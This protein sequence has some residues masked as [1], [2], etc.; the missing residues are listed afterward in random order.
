MKLQDVHQHFSGSELLGGS[1]GIEREGLRVTENGRL[2]QTDHPEI[3][4]SKLDNPYITTD[5]SESQIEVVTPPYD[6]LPRTYAVLEGLCDIVNNEIGPDEYL[7]PG[8]MPCV[9]PDD[10]DI[11]IAKYGDS[12]KAKEYEKYRR[13]LIGKYGSKKQLLTGIHF[14][15][16]LSDAFIE[17]LRRIE[18][19]DMSVRDFRDRVYLKIA[20]GYLE[21]RWLVIYLTGCSSARHAS[22]DCA[23][24]SAMVQADSESYVSDEGP[25]F[26]NSACGYK[27]LVDFFPSYD[28]VEAYVKD[29]QSF[30]DSGLI[31]EAKELYTQI[32]LKTKDRD[33][34]LESLKQTG[35]EYLEIRTIDLNLFDK[36][37]VA[38]ND[39]R[40]VQL[41]LL[42]SLFRDETDY[43]DWQ[44]E[45]LANELRTASKGLS[46]ALKLLS[47][48]SEIPFKEYA[49]EVIGAI[50][51]MDA[52]LELGCSEIISE[53]RGR[54]EKPETTYA[55]CE[56]ALV[57][58]DGYLP[59]MMKFAKAYKEDSYHFRYLF[60]GFENYELSTQ[61]L[62]KEAITRGLKVEELDPQD[63][64]ISVTGKDGTG[65]LIKQA[66]KTQADNYASVLAMENKVVTKKI[67]AQHGIPVPEG[68][69]FTSMDAARARLSLY[70][71]RP[72]VIKPKSTNYGTGIFIFEHG[73]SEK[74]LLDAAEGAFKYDDTILIEEYLPGPEYRFLTIGGKT[75]AVMRRVAANV[76]GDGKSTIRELMDKKND[77]PFRGNH[78]ETPLEN[79][80]VDQQT[81][82]Y[83]KG[84]GLTPESVPEDS[85]TVYLR[86]NSNISTG[87]D[88]VDVTDE[89]PAYFKKIAEEAADAIGAVFCGVDM[90]IEDYTNTQSVYG[91]IELNFN[92]A[93]HMHAYPY[94]GK[95]RRTGEYI[96]RA[97]GLLEDTPETEK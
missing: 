16:S 41:L 80:R 62:I 42:W 77:H 14:N 6:S 73:A 75:A 67:L 85:E 29:V 27:N 19:P 69:E 58:K 23:Q 47:G 86:G 44:Q 63:N 97:L 4:G 8:S 45:G 24:T 18:A 26:R 28:S 10:R 84:Q 94:K 25:S 88:S 50:E 70:A 82:L 13:N 87:G 36:A 3:F 74:D 83:L 91:I 56:A 76:T 31:S 95:E 89:M 40:F 68:A 60:K 5:F 81:V 78:Y 35:I 37:G 32:R 11:H 21:Y 53:M 9:S 38:L 33:H 79:L 90:I 52:D 54:V 22:Y 51:K 49:M 59:A 66:T 20:K 71:N 12:P 72:V 39:L 55:A 46:P 1:F 2:A 15:Y 48:G 65:Q 93:T 43:P 34:V 92:P 96:L 57:R 61:I 30:V 7:W 64:F 17:K